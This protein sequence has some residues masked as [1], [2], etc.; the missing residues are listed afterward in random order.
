MQRSLRTQLLIG[1]LA[2]G[3]GILGGCSDQPKNTT[4]TASLTAVQPST[5]D[6]FAFYD[7]SGN[8]ITAEILPNLNYAT[9]D[10][11]LPAQVLAVVQNHR[12]SARNVA[13]SDEVPQLDIARPERL[14]V[15][16]PWL[17]IEEDPGAP[18][19]VDNVSIVNINNR[20][21][22]EGNCVT[23]EPCS[24]EYLTVVQ[25]DLESDCY[26]LSTF[27]F[28]H[29]NV[30][31]CDGEF[32]NTITLNDVTIATVTGTCGACGLVPPPPVEVDQ[33]DTLPN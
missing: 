30:V 31:D 13:P 32:T 22:F 2:V 15:C 4:A 26:P 9:S 11:D 27:W 7:G 10:E 20:G 5:L 23:N 6:M 16:E 12:A 29:L 18:D 8:D 25:L 14:D 28:T 3:L 24:F 33:Q 17:S 21:I 1:L 19:C